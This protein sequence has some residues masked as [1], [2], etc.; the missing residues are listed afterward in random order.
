MT[1]MGLLGMTACHGPKEAAKGTQPS[2]NPQDPVVEPDA[3]NY[4]LMYGVPQMDFRVSGRVVDAEGRPVEGMQVV[5]V[6]QTIDISPDYMQEDNPQVQQYLRA[7]SD[8]TDIDGRFEA[9][10][11]DVPVEVQRVI[12]RDIDGK[13]GGSYRDQMLE[14]KFGPEDQTEEGSRWYKGQRA[15][16][17]EIVVEEK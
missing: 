15:K 16:E 4:A 9:S 6:N 11:R 8:T 17:I 13:E 14:V 7:A 3:R 5:L 2:P 10:V 12:V 1:T